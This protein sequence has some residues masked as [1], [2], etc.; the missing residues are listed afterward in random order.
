MARMFPSAPGETTQSE[1]ERILFGV[2]KRDLPNDWIVL[3]SVGLVIHP[4]KPWA[5]IDFVLIGPPGIFCLEVKG[6]RVGRRN[7]SW[8][9]T[10]RHGSETTKAE[11]P[12][13]QVGKASSALWKYLSTRVEGIGMSLLGYG[14]LTPDIRFSIREPDVLPE[15]VYDADDVGRPF[16]DFV[17]RLA[18]YWQHRLGDQR[19]RATAGLAPDMREAILY[20]LR[21]DFDTRLSLRARADQVEREIVRLTTEQFRV[22]DGLAAND[23]VLVLG[24][25]GTGKTLLAVEEARRQG[26]QGKRVLLTCYSRQLAEFLK[27]LVADLPTVSVSTLH[28]FMVGTVERAGHTSRLPDASTSDLMAVHYPAL[29]YETLLEVGEPPFDVIVL[30]EGQD[31]LRDAYIDVLDAAV[32]GGLAQGTWRV[33]YDPRQDVFSGIETTGMARIRSR[34]AATYRLTLNCRNTAPIATTIGLMT[35]FRPDETLSV[36]GPEVETRWF[37]GADALR[38]SVSAAVTQMLSG[39]LSPTE[40]VVISPNTLDRSRLA[41]GLINTLPLVSDCAASNRRAIRFHTVSGFK[42]L[43]AEAVVLVDLPDLSSPESLMAAY[44]GGSRARAMLWVFLP[45]TARGDYRE[46]AQ[47]FGELLVAPPRLAD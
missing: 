2:I 17:D 36:D 39:G 9:F 30:D 44:L 20:A 13:E 4:T 28:Q 12:F 35:G 18:I 38:R 43:E 25:A 22:L 1:A 14:V 34:M 45:E 32:A 29:C 24:G 23:R 41:A 31:L 10:N 37:D 27:G 6:G 26:S 19:H 8:V 46:K 15:V 40:I 42:G 3:H 5:E 11:G 21:P 16:T 47:R 33:F 7:G